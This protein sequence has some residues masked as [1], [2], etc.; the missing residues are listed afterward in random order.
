MSKKTKHCRITPD[1]ELKLIDAMQV[2]YKNKLCSY[3][4]I[5]MREA[6]ELL[7]KSKGINFA[8]EEIRVK[9]R[10]KEKK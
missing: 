1:L 7:T 4:E 3:K 9:P 2:R 6:T 8:L 10:R 5:N